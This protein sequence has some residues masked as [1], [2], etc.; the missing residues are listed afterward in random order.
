MAE[1]VPQDGPVETLSS[2][3]SLM[4]L[5]FAEAAHSASDAASAASVGAGEVDRWQH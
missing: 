3:S 5:F 1:M 2:T 4:T